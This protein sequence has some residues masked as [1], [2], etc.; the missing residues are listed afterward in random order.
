[1]FRGYVNWPIEVCL[2]SNLQSRNSNWVV[3]NSQLLNEFALFDLKT[4]S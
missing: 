3:A 1:M 2:N 4:C